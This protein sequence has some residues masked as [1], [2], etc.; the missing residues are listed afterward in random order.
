MILHA[1]K[2]LMIKIKLEW[3]FIILTLIAIWITTISYFIKIN[4]CV[5][6]NKSGFKIVPI[7]GKGY[8]RKYDVNTI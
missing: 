7:I 8:R 5:T 2:K 4:K 3:S 1:L 6:Y